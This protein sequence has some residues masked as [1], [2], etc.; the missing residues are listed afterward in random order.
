[1]ADAAAYKRDPGG[2]F[3]VFTAPLTVPNPGARDETVSSLRFEVR[4]TLTGAGNARSELF[5]GLRL[6]LDQGGCGQQRA[7]AEDAVRA[8]LDRWTRKRHAHRSF[9]CTPVRAA[10]RARGVRATRFG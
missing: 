6:F 7:T 10:R 1:M 4:S 8:T 5:R 3:E 9:L 2:G